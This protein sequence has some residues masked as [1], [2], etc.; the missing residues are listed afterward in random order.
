MVYLV[1]LLQVPAQTLVG[2]VAVAVR[3]QWLLRLQ[4]VQLLVVALLLAE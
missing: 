1:L 2:L 3:L 4:S